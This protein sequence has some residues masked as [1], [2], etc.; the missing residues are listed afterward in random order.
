M[1]LRHEFPEVMRTSCLV[2]TIVAVIA[3][4][5]VTCLG[6][7]TRSWFDRRCAILEIEQLGGKVYVEYNATGVK[8]LTPPE[9][10]A[11]QLVGVAALNRPVDIVVTGHLQETSARV[12]RVGKVR[13]LTV[14]QEVFEESDIE[15][16]GTLKEVPQIVLFSF[17]DNSEVTRKLQRLLP[18]CNVVI[19]RENSLE[20]DGSFGRSRA[21]PPIQ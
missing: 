21:L 7:A 15:C 10:L 4:A 3:V 16:L 9:R 20:P 13:S 12:G 8:P 5:L 18:H 2:L 14:A 17:R 1:I 11:H 6:V 19:S